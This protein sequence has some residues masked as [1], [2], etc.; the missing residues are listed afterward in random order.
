MPRL[1]RGASKL[2][3]FSN[4]LS[5]Q[6]STTL[7]LCQISCVGAA[8]ELRFVKFQR[9]CNFNELQNLTARWLL[10]ELQYLKIRD[11][12]TARQNLKF[13]QNYGIIEK[14]RKNKSVHWTDLIL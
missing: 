1:R 5:F 4:F 7:T 8:N 2:F 6:I 14:K 12:G 3:F 9:S 13:F 11:E 10:N